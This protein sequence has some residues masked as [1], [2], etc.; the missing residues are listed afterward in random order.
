MTSDGRRER[1]I[2]AVILVVTALL[3]LPKFWNGFVYDDTFVF[4]ANDVIHDPANIPSLFTHNALWVV[5]HSD[6]MT[7]DTYRP[8]TLATFAIDSL[9]TGRHPFGYHFINLLLHLVCVVLVYSTARRV[10]RLENRSFAWLAAAWFAVSPWLGEAHIWINGRSDPLC[11]LFVLSAVL[12]WD[13]ALYGSRW[14]LHAAAG[15]LMFAALLSKE[16]ALG[17]LPSLLFWPSLRTR[18]PALSRRVLALSGIGIGAVLYLVV[19]VAVLGGVRSFGDTTQ[20]GEAISNLGLVFF[21]GLRAT[22][23]PRPPYLR[24]MVESY[25]LVPPPA[26]W[27]ALVGVPVV[28][29]LSLCSRRRHPA[30]AWSVLFFLGALAPVSVITTMNWTGFGRYLYLPLAGLSIGVSDTVVTELRY[31]GVLRKRRIRQIIGAAVALYLASLAFLLHRFTYDFRNDGTLYGAA[32]ENAPNQAYGHA[33]LGISLVYN[34]YPDVGVEY[35]RKAVRL[36]PFE[37]S[38]RSFLGQALVRNGQLDEAASLAEQWLRH[39]RTV[40][41]PEYL[42]IIVEATQDTDPPRAAA[43]AIACVRVNS[44]WGSCLERLHNL[45][46]GHP[47]SAEY[48]TVVREQLAHPRNRPIAS[49]VGAAV[50]PSFTP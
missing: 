41:A 31:L 40:D 10:M 21:D 44:A 4:L 30:L 8:L 26:R 27:A 49:L 29:A 7:V 47:R 14:G 32:I 36:Q 33:Y 3:L 45:T 42:L 23:I 38:Y 16:V 17:V 24:S 19:R 5:G 39:G 20:L 46:N 1:W 6:P 9:W 35:S 34:G 25:A 28:I 2:L 48:R 15:A 12:V 11:T 22:L 43:A 50:E 37:A 18:F 13:R